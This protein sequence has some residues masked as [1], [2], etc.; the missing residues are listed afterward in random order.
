VSALEPFRRTKTRPKRWNVVAVPGGSP[1]RGCFRVD[2]LATSDLA[3]AR[4][5][6][7]VAPGDGN[8]AMA[9]STTREASMPTYDYGCERC[10]P[11]TEARPMAEFAVPQP[12]PNC[13]DLAARALTSPAIGGGARETPFAAP[14]RAHPGGCRCCA[15]PAGRFCAEAV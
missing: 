3:C 14:G 7:L 2:H 6:G 11:F 10:G 13:G 1:R 9:I 15:A 12:C 5:A 8:I 4:P